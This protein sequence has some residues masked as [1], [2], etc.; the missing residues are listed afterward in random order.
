MSTPR[1]LN[2]LIRALL[3]SAL[4]TAAIALLALSPAAHAGG[5]VTP[6]GDEP[7]TE[8][9]PGSKAKLVGK[10]I[11]PEDAPNAVKKVIAAANEI[12]N[13]P[14]KYGGGHGRWKDRGYDC[15]GA[16]ELRAAWRQVAQAPDRLERNGALRQEGQGAVD[17]GLRRPQP[18]LHRRR[19]T[20]LR[21][22]GRQG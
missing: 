14:Y 18:R 15:S 6:S 1:P 19:R 9:T 21:H 5:G 11:A 20:A 4:L 13:K 8:T 7:G 17:H 12:R 3:P 2:T 22:G 10:A 16:G